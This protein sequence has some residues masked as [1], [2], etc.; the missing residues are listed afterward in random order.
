KKYLLYFIMIIIIGR[1]TPPPP[2]IGGVTIYV[3]RL[4]K[5][6]SET[7]HKVL[8]IELTIKIHGYLALFTLVLDSINKKL[9]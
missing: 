1:I 5:N 9:L 8:F 7:S 2:P 3:D 4:I 6:L